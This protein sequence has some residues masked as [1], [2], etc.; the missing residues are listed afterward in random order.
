MFFSS[1]PFPF[2]FPAFAKA[3]AGRRVDG[4]PTLP[5]KAD[6]L[7][8]FERSVR[9]ANKSF[10]YILYLPVILPITHS[11]TTMGNRAAA[12]IPGYDRILILCSGEDSNLHALRRYHLKVVRL[13]SFATRAL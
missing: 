5:P 8:G 9:R 3:T 2:W 1:F 6:K 7:S 4:F 11:R 12:V 10:H 13:A